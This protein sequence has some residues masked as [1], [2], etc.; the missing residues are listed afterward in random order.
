MEIF[1]GMPRTE[2]SWAS[3][4]GILVSHSSRTGGCALVLMN[5]IYFYSVA[6]SL[7]AGLTVLPYCERQF[8]CFWDIAGYAGCDGCR[9]G[10]HRACVGC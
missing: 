9:R 3:R 10:V 5:R 1:Q 2:V 4:L 8:Q 7:G 6:G